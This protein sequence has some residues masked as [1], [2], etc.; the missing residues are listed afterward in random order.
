MSSLD[1]ESVIDL[2]NDHLDTPFE[3][4]F[5]DGVQFEPDV[6]LEPEK[7]R[8]VREIVDDVIGREKRDAVIEVNKTV[9]VGDPVNV[10]RFELDGVP[11]YELSPK[12]EP[13]TPDYDNK[14]LPVF[15]FLGAAGMT[16]LIA[17]ILGRPMLQV[18]KQENEEKPNNGH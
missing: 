11:H 16:L 7:P 1:R 13:P 15:L 10:T 2:A 6:E 12:G 18:Q 17:L 3:T 8:T 14:R 9:K 5:E 4:A